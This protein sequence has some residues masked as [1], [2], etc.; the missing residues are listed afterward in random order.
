MLSQAVRGVIASG[1]GTGKAGRKKPQELIGGFTG[2]LVP[3]LA[4]SLNGDA[5]T[6]LFVCVSQAPDNAT[7]SK[8]ALQFGETFS[9]LEMG[10][11]PQKFE[12]VAKLR[13]DLLA[14][15]KANDAM[16]AKGVAG[17]FMGV[18]QAQALHYMQMLAVLERFGS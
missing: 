2:D 16:L 3:V 1:K 15:Q 18:R 17:K 5:L 8:V 9:Q 12:S 10:K 13:K 4:D 6:A 7:Q 11:R 14:K